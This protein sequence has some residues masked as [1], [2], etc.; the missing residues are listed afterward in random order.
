VPVFLGDAMQWNLQ[1]TGD[2]AELRVPVP[3]SPSLRVPAGF[4]EDQE[5]V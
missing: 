3:D 2:V 5:L 4:A 1:Q